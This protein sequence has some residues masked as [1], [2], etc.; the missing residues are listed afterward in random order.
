MA[1]KTGTKKAGG[2]KAPKTVKAAPAVEPAV[3]VLA[4]V[5]GWNQKKSGPWQK[6][7]KKNH[8]RL[9]QTGVT[10]NVADGNEAA[11]K[12]IDK[13]NAAFAESSTRWEADERYG[14]QH[15]NKFGF[16]HRDGL[17]RLTD[18]AIMLLMVQA[19]EEM[20]QRAMFKGSTG[21]APTKRINPALAQSFIKAFV[22]WLPQR[23]EAI[24]TSRKAQAYA[25]VTEDG[26]KTLQPVAA[27]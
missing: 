11:I 12:S 5:G 17:T 14:R 25:A 4:V 27:S 16:M 20:A 9:N 24:K 19:G 13:A 21:I 3:D 26:E 1:K 23:P 2:K 8:I 22:A 18:D 6:Y 15:Y 7:V 10:V